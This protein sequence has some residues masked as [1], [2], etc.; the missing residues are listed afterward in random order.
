MVDDGA[1]TRCDEPTARKDHAQGRASSDVIP[2]KLVDY[3]STFKS[4]EAQ[5][6]SREGLRE[7]TCRR[8]RRSFVRKRTAARRYAHRKRARGKRYHAYPRNNGQQASAHG[9]APRLDR[10]WDAHTARPP[11]GPGDRIR[12][13]NRTCCGAVRMWHHHLR[14]C[15]VSSHG[16]VSV[17][18]PK[19]GTRY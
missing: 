15:D 10:T 4:G 13:V 5:R 17:Q 16:C 14:R 11:L 19:G 12:G 6:R 3:S 1:S 2:D 18:G 9:R 7:P 8:A